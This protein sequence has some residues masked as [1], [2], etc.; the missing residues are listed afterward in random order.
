[1]IAM[2]SITPAESDGMNNVVR[3]TLDSMI[4]Y[5]VNLHS[6]DTPKSPILPSPLRPSTSG[7]TITAATAATAATANVP[8]VRI[9][10]QVPPEIATEQP[11][12]R[13]LEITARVP[14]PEKIGEILF[15]KATIAM[16]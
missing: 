16:D 6:D 2:T 10:L 8:P 3:N 9:Y 12:V 4:N 15:L 13:Q 5:V 7:N 1:M 11:A 14:I